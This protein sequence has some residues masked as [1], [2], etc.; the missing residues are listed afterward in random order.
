MY[1]DLLGIFGVTLY[2][3]EFEHIVFASLGLLMMWG[4]FSSIQIYRA[5]RR[6]EGVIQGG[7]VLA[8]LVWSFCR[9]IAALESDYELMFSE[10][11]VL[12]SYAFCI[13]VGIILGML[14]ARQIAKKRGDEPDE[15]VKLCVMMVVFGFLGARAAHVIVDYETYVNACF[16]PELVGSSHS[17][18]FRVLNFAEGG[19]TFYGGVIAGMF[20][21]AWF[22]I[23]RYRRGLALNGLSV[24]DML[25][26]ALAIAHACGRVG[27]LAAGCCWGAITT[28]TLGIRYDA[29]SFAY[30]ELIRNPALQAEMLET[31]QTPLLHATQIYEAGGELILYF[32]LWVMLY[33]GAKLGRMVGVWFIAYGILRFVVE[34][35]RDDAER[36]YYF[37]RVITPIN[38]LFKVPLDHSTILSTSQGIAM[39][40]V[41]IGVVLLV[42]SSRQAR[43]R[44]D[45]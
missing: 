4:I 18:C 9:S 19:L 22:F 23:R 16:H 3:A 37:E 26:G 21:V 32:I 2:G 43:E 42:L 10:P 8:L 33:K 39:V 44:R 30:A 28:G 11:L 20:V 31:G 29:H 25:A 6:V 34:F 17:D 45:S 36:G 40:M 35:M 41:G 5:G 14:T 1:P 12:H 13:L 38:A 15:I 27:C 7:V 24:L